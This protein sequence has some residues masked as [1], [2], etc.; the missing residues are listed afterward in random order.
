MEKHLSIEH[1]DV[2]MLYSQNQ[3]LQKAQIADPQ[4][5]L[6]FPCSRLCIENGEAWLSQ[7]EY[8]TI[9]AYDF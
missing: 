2:T 1:H 6:F 3:R 9:Y 7:K 8:V 4:G 5:K